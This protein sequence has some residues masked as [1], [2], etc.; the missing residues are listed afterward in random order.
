MAMMLKD[1][2]QTIQTHK[3]LSPHYTEL[4]EILEEILILREEY[5]HRMKREIF[6]VEEKLIAAKMAG[7]LPLVDFSSV[8]LRSHG[9]Q[10]LFS[11]PPG[12]RREAV[13]RRNGRNGE[14]NPRG[15]DQLQRPDLRILQPPASGRRGG[16]ADEE[17]RELLR[18]GGT[19]HRREP[20]T[21][22]G[23]G[24]GAHTAMSSGSRNGR[25]AT[26]P[27]AAG[28]PRSARSGTMREPVTSSATSAASSGNIGGSNAPSAA[29]RSSRPSP[30]SRSKRTTGTGSMSATSANGTSRSWTSGIRRRR[31]TWTW[32]TSPRSISICWPMTRATIS[33]LGSRRTPMDDRHMAEIIRLLEKELEQAGTPHRFPAGRGTPRSL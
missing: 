32:R 8:D 16:G 25:R 31:R 30:I 28:N 11:G 13:T 18:S 1:S 29:T 5:R 24:R 7:G 2:L 26:A 14:E 21:G 15:R 12:D 19:L 10:G 3:T 33:I 20:E 6:P 27:S 4:L 9:T 17:E 23:E 22:P